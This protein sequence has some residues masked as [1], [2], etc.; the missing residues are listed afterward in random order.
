MMPP[1]YFCS[2]IP[3]SG[4]T[5]LLNLLAQNP[6]IHATPTNDLSE[7]FIRV[8]NIWMEQIGF[9][10]QG[11]KTIE[12]RILSTL[13]GMLCGFFLTEFSAGKVVIDKSRTWLG[14]IE[15][16][17]MVFNRKVKI[18]VPV[19][20]V[21]D[22]LASFERVHRKSTLTCHT[23]DGPL[24]AIRQT[25]VGRAQSFLGLEAHLG[26]VIARLRDVIDRDLRNRLLIVPYRD[27]TT[28]PLEVAEWITEEIG[29]PQFNYNSQNVRQLINED[30]SVYG[31]ELHKIREGAIEPQQHSA[32]KGVLNEGFVAWV[33]KEYEDINDLACPR[34]RPLKEKSYGL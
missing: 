11:L 19:R 23:Y 2:C 18:I 10:A 3:R 14:H 12:P 17:E 13:Q 1:L 24:H 28:R 33:Q 8:R 30:D 5:L 25:I 27:L 6:S 4:S 31:V 7:L 20:A 29:L 16:L 9:K 26:M 22:V 34:S 15:L 21:E 32:W